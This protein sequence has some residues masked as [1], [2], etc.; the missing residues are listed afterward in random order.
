MANNFVGA[1]SLRGAF[2]MRRT[3]AVRRVSGVVHA[4]TLCNCAREPLE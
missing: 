4:R 2:C 3:L 1:P